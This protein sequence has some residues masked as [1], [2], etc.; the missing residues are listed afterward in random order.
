MKF[1]KK[2]SYSLIILIIIS[3]ISI[4]WASGMFHPKNIMPAEIKNNVLSK[5]EIEVEKPISILSWNIQFMAGGKNN[6][7]FYD[8]GNDDFPNNPTVYKNIISKVATVIKKQNPDVI[9]LQEV[10]R[11]SKRSFYID[12]LQE[13]LQLLPQ[14]YSSYSCTPYH[15]VNFMMLLEMPGKINLQLCTISKYKIVKSTRY[16]L[17]TKLDINFILQMFHLKRA[18]LGTKFQLNNGKL[19]SVLNTHFSAWAQNTKTIDKQVIKANKVMQQAQIMGPVLLAGDLNSLSSSKFLKFVHPQEKNIYPK[20][21]NAIKLLFDN[22][23]GFPNPSQLTSKNRQQ[24]LTYLPA[25]DHSHKPYSAID[26]I[27]ISKHLEFIN[28]KV[29]QENNATISDHY[30][31]AVKLK[32]N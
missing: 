10:D 8:K 28:Q 13:I 4:Y 18:I 31:L 19:F 3:I 2:L 22:Y 20:D 24:F 29:L 21:K 1:I 26:F 17:P 23:Q 9:L 25:M 30:P 6:H 16:A 11:G 12:E 27:F 15:K 5:S 32:F 14:D 7:F